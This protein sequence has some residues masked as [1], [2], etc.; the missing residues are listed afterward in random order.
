M[1]ADQTSSQS[2]L[3]AG[4]NNLLKTITCIDSMCG[5]LTFLMLSALIRIHRRLTFSDFDMVS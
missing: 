4:N 5:F 3:K 2:T 1:T